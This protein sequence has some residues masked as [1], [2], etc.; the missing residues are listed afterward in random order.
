MTPA[1]I[2][3]ERLAEIRL[4]VKR[5]RYTAYGVAI[6]DLLALADHR[7]AEVERLEAEVASF[8]RFIDAVLSL[9]PHMREPKPEIEALLDWV[10]KAKSYEAALREVATANF[11]YEACTAAREALEERP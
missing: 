7:A 10:N 6:R 5:W 2:S 1:P 9:E 11:L 4:A 3:P 8:R